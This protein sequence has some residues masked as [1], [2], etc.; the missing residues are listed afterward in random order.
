MGRHASFHL[1]HGE[2]RLPPLDANRTWLIWIEPVVERTL[3]RL[4][5]MLDFEQVCHRRE[6]VSAER[7]A[8]CDPEIPGIVLRAAANPCGLPYRLIDGNHRVHRL[9]GAGQMCGP[10]FVFDFADVADCVLDYEVY[11]RTL[12]G[13]RGRRQALLPEAALAGRPD[14]PDRR[15]PPGS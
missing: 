10:F 2:W 8:A 4:P 6:V 14:G 7:L 9:R 11:M 5:V 15:R 12:R 13:Q 3:D 1:I